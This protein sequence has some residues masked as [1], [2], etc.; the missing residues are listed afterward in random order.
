MENDMY[1][2][3]FLDSLEL[4]IRKVST[5]KSKEEALKL[6]LDIKEDIELRKISRIEQMLDELKTL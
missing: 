1:L 5:A 2:Q 4:A 3:G 6:L